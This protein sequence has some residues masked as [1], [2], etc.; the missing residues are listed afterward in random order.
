ME[1]V[2]FSR[3][4]FDDPDSVACDICYMPECESDDNIV[5]CDGC[6]TV[7]H[8]SCYG[9]NE[10]PTGSWLC[11][12]CLIESTKPRCLMCPLPHGAMKKTSCA[13]GYIHI[14][15]ALWIDDVTFEDAARREGI[16]IYAKK[17]PKREHGVC[18]VCNIFEG[19][20]L[21]CSKDNCQSSYHVTCAQRAG[22]RFQVNTSSEDSVKFISYCRKH[23]MEV[24]PKNT[25]LTNKFVRSRPV[26]LSLAL[27]NLR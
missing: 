8:Q 3:C 27:F 19:A 16:N 22:Y 17:K 26:S 7:V 12:V 6:E 2:G 23:T 11:D 9:L 10:V 25:T 15:C 20:H 18:Q 24:L 13:S 14:A 4:F 1:Q 5:F 21:F